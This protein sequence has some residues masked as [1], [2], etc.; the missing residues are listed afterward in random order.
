[1]NTIEKLNYKNQ[2]PVLVHNAPEEVEVLVNDFKALC[3]TH[4]TINNA[5]RYSFVLCF[6]KNQSDIEYIVHNVTPQLSN[7]AVFWVAYP[8]KTSKKYRCEIDRD[9]GWDIIGLIGYEGVRMV[10]V[11]NDWSAIRFRHIDKIKK[12]TRSSKIAISPE[13]KQKSKK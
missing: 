7:D 13:G 2:T 1:M 6:I 4:T 11:D 9:H 5:S 10:A 12:L 8:K 3:V